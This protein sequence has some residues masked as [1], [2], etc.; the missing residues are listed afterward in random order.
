MKHYLDDEKYTD[1]LIWNQQDIAEE[2]TEILFFITGQSNKVKKPLKL[3]TT[4]TITERL[5]E[6]LDRIEELL[7]EYRQ[8]VAELDEMERGCGEH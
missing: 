5:L 7:I 8:T 6:H 1:Y 3:V 4:Y 2:V